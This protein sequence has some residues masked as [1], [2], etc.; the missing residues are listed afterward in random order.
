MPESV[1]TP[2]PAP[3]EV[4]KLASLMTPQLSF[5]HMGLFVADVARMRD[6]YTRVPGFAV[7]DRGVLETGQ[8]EDGFDLRPAVRVNFIASSRDIATGRMRLRATNT[9]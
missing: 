3:F 1:T 5:S 7:T 6:F 8:S 9:V 4:L 2:K